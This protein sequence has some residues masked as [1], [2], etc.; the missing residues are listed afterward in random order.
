[1]RTGNPGAEFITVPNSLRAKAR[2]DP[3]ALATPA[4]VRNTI[5]KIN[6]LK[7]RR[8]NLEIGILVAMIVSN[9]GT[10]RPERRLVRLHKT[11]KLLGSLLHL[12][13]GTEFMHAEELCDALAGIANRIVENGGKADSDALALLE[14]TAMA[15]HLCFHPEKTVSSI[16]AEIELAVSRINQTASSA[17]AV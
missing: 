1:M 16:T 14:Q 4:A 8:C 17:A 2:R 7:I 10:D 3:T 15:L 6:G 9:V 5:A 12:I 13:N 11:G